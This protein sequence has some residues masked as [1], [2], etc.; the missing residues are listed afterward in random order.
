M[1]KRWIAFVLLIALALPG[2]A[3]AQDSLPPVRATEGPIVPPPICIDFCPPP[4]WNMDGLEIPYQRVTVTIAD[5]VATTHVEQLFRNPNDWTLEGTYYFP[6]P[7]GAAVSQLT[8]WV[9]GAPIEAQLLPADKARA[10]YD[11]I[12]RQLRDPALLEYVGQDAIQANVFPIPPGEERRIEI[13]YTTLLT[14][15]NGALHY[16]YPQSAGLY[17]ETPLAEQSI[18]VEIASNEAIRTLYSPSHRV[19]IARDGEFRATVGYE[20][21]NPP[22]DDFELYY[23]VSPEEI[24]LNLLSDKEPGEDGFFVLL[25][26]PGLETGE[27]V[28][29]DV[30]LVLDTS[31]SMEGEKM[32]QARQAARYVLEH[33]NPDDRFA[34]VAFNTTISSYQ[35]TLLPAGEA[36]AA[37]VYSDGLIA[38]GGTN[39]SGALL[40]AATLVQPE[41]PT[42]ILFLTDGL[43][44][45]GITETSL[46]LDSVAAALP[47]NARLFA[48]GVGDDVDTTLLDTL[49]QNH[50]G[51]TT[52]VRPGQAIDESVS[53]FYAR[54]GAP[55]LTD[56][57]I[58]YG[59][60]VDQVY[61]VEL[62][63]LFAGTQLV[64]TGRYR[65]GGPATITLSGVT[66]GRPQTFTYADQT[67]RAEGGEDFIPRLWATRAIGHLMQQIRLR[68]DDP[69]LVQSVVALST[70]YG[71][72]TPYTSFLIQEDDIAAQTGGLA[73][74]TVTADM[75]LAAPEAVSGAE[76][77]E[78]AATEGELAAAEA[79]MALPTMMPSFASAPGE[80]VAQAPV[81]T[82]GGRTFFL[83]DGVWVDS[84]Y[85]PAAGQPAV[86][87]FAS[88]DYFALLSARPELGEALALGDEV[89]LVVEGAA[90]RITA[91]GEAAGDGTPPPATPGEATPAV[92]QAETPPGGVTLAPA[93]AP[94]DEAASGV[95]AFGV[96]LGPCGAALLLPLALAL[97]AGARRRRG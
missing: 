82:A 36:A 75:A 5:Q 8:M 59:T 68:G 46:L 48:F 31:G 20:A 97:V 90:Y 67:Y 84:A 78:R 10:V 49:A 79:P 2:L 91:T 81:Q 12:V 22:L 47:A 34:L 25:V 56:I 42:T 86:I 65:Q 92:A 13:E 63:D 89:L 30:I 23:T 87:P 43:A 27:V 21:S 54:V 37:A 96:G 55:V 60:A 11:E 80:A 41:R 35:P 74:R 24:G 29:K 52:Y 70:R 58:D 95:S 40:E 4:V 64:V 19:A 83:R 71:I 38:A 77:V 85:D 7:P 51:T 26:A 39:I 50:R 1:K 72:I 76:A 33:L 88:D 17:T 16:V 14:A 57:S 45:E 53:A 15:D 69:E 18:R 62:P 61:P 3:R 32:A 66:N 73:T 93:V 44:T 94:A 28:A 6:L 9:N